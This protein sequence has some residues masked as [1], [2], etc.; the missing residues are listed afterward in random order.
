MDS[1]VLPVPSPAPRAPADPVLEPQQLLISSSSSSSLGRLAPSRLIQ[2]PDELLDEVFRFAYEGKDAPSSRPVSRRLWP[3]QERQLCRRVRL[4]SVSALELFSKVIQRQ[5]SCAHVVTVLHV[6]LGDAALDWDWDATV[7]ASTHLG[8]IVPRL[9]RLQE[10]RVADVGELID[11]VLAGGP[12]TLVK[13][14]RFE[15]VLTLTMFY[16]T[17][18]SGRDWFEK[19]GRLPALEHIKLEADCTYGNAFFRWREPHFALSRLTS[20]HLWSTT[21]EFSSWHMPNMSA[22]IPNLIELELSG[23]KSRASVDEVLRVV[24]VGIRRLVLCDLG[25]EGSYVP[26]AELVT[27]RRLTYF[28]GSSASNLAASRSTTTSFP[29]SRASLTCATSSSASMPTSPSR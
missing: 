22:V 27:P 15:L 7:V 9:E 4:I 1:K 28:L 25:D 18:V 19:L 3:H 21:G 23:L 24:P 26:G 5:P 8:S 12:N 20:L 2:L 11:A 13:L 10:L 14:R 6:E 17:G 16:R 29:P